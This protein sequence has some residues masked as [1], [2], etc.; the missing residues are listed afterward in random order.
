MFHVLCGF[1]V[2]RFCGT[3]LEFSTTDLAVQTCHSVCISS[4][5]WFQISVACQCSCAV[6]PFVSSSSIFI[7]LFVFVLFSQSAFMNYYW[8]CQ[9]LFQASKLMSKYLKAVPPKHPEVEYFWPGNTLL[10]CLAVFNCL[11]NYLYSFLTSSRPLMCLVSILHSV[12][13]LAQSRVMP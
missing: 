11:L 12:L 10:Y 7:V 5:S 6:L 3:L 2:I 4:V 8:Y 1:H 9:V 13:Q